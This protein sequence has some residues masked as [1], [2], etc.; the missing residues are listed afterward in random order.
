MLANLIKIIRSKEMHIYVIEYN[1]ADI[2]QL[3][4]L[5]I[6]IKSTKTKELVNYVN[7]TLNSRVLIELKSSCNIN[8][9]L[10]SKA[11][12]KN[13]V[14]SIEDGSETVMELH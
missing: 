6:T 9:L 11:I 13:N 7:D 10:A 4:E 5:L 2:Q 12:Y 3:D 8:A 14:W 1:K